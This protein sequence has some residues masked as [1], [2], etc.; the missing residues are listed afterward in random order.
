MRM[1][2]AGGLLD[3]NGT[4]IAEAIAFLLMVL[5]LARWVYPR[6]IQ[7]ATAREERIAAGLRA[8]QEAEQRLQQVQEEVR[9]TLDEARGQAREILNRANSDASVEAQGVLQQAREQAEA[10]IERARAE[11]GS[12]RDRA[13]QDLRSE[14]STLVIAATSKLVGETLDAPKHERL[15]DEA[16]KGVGGNGSSGARG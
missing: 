13:I 11:I 15:I 16:L 7:I 8:A 12:E 4:L 5:I 14:V 9:K 1:V 6:V 3:V 10:Q 2:A